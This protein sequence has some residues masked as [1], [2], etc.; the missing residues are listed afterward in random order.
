M[1]CKHKDKQEECMANRE[2][3]PP[4]VRGH[5]RHRP[6]GGIGSRAPEN[7]VFADAG[8]EPTEGEGAPDGVAGEAVNRPEENEGDLIYCPNDRC[9]GAA[10]AS[11]GWKFCG[12]CGTS[13]SRGGSAKR[14]GVSFLE[15]DLEEYLF[16]GYVVRE[17]SM[18]G[19][20]KITLKSP[21]SKDWGDIDQYIME[22]GW[23]KKGDGSERRVSDFY[24]RQKNSMCVVAACM[25]KLNG[26]SIGETLA[27]RMRWLEERGSGFL[28][29][30]SDKVSLFN[31][32][33]AEFL[34]EADTVSGS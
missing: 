34:S 15:A 33:I 13:F 18:L 22:G 20:Y 16:R 25:V 28:D 3:L 2:N 4:D 27:D 1:L 32:A 23:S 31:Q 10:E 17:I 24:L 7:K 11:L 6:G 29:I 14:L 12:R 8:A 26:E 21:Q 19:R 9:G 30:A 5:V